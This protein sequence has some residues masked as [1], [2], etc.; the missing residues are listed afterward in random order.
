MSGKT[1]FNFAFESPS[2]H[3]LQ[4]NNRKHNQDESSTIE[5]HNHSSSMW[6][7]AA[8]HPGCLATAAGSGPNRALKPA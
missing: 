3:N 5:F 8:H 6:E 2:S 7:T 4:R 1:N